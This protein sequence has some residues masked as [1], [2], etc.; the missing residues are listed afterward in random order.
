M[1]TTAL[2]RVAGWLGRGSL[3]AAVLA[4][5]AAS[6]HAQDDALLNALVKKGVISSAEANDIRNE[7]ELE[8]AKEGRGKIELNKGVTKLKIYGKARLRYQWNQLSAQP[9]VSPPPF[10]GANPNLGN[11]P[12]ESQWDQSRF[13]YYFKFGVQYW[14]QKNLYGGLEFAS[15]DNNDSYNAT[16]GKGYGR[17][18]VFLSLLYLSYEPTDW[19][20]L[21]AGKQKNPLE[22]TSMVWDSDVNPD[23][24]TEEFWFEV[25][26]EFGIGLTLG[27]WVYSEGDDTEDAGNF[28]AGDYLP[29]TDQSPVMQFVFQV[30][31]EY[32]FMEYKEVPYSSSDP[33]DMKS[34]GTVTEAK[35]W[36]TIG[37]APGFMTYLGGD[38]TEVNTSS[39]GFLQTNGTND[40]NVVT[41]PG[42][43]KWKMWKQKF[44]FYWDFA[45]NITGDDRIQNTYLGDFRNNGAYTPAQWNALR[46]ANFGLE[47]NLAWLVGV[48]V[49]ENKKAGNWSASVDFR[50]IGL[51]AVDPNLNDS[52]FNLGFLNGQG[53]RAKVA[54]SFTDNMVGSI[55]YFNTWNYKNDLY[56]PVGQSN[57]VQQL[58]G[59]NGT[60]I[61]QADL[62]WKF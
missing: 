18:A 52:D 14:F 54:Y 42:Y 59:A 62:V 51:G 21:T 39:P 20:K 12:N 5:G 45:Y 2:K 32:N 23:G 22:T 4:V 33:K 11:S 43:L 7:V 10:G 17:Q 13:R 37:F 57:S 53:I 16:F 49:G 50:Q 28:G 46:N 55:T 27:Q 35:P 25:S 30:P 19:L 61:V 44:K 9:P 47:D 34:M 6:S 29:A 8:R 56:L 31:M 38:S 60:Q 1:K 15:G 3:A 26:D 36:L 41:A 40:L 48:K 24:L 58:T